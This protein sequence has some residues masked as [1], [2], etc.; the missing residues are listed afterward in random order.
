[1][2]PTVT[3][4]TPAWSKS[5][6]RPAAPA[7]V[8]VVDAVECIA[9]VQ[10][11]DAAAARALVDRLAP[12]V[13]R[14]VRSHLPRRME[15]SDLTQMVFAK[16]FSKLDQYSGRV[17]LEHW[18]S[19]VAVNTCLNALAYERVRPEIRCADLTE[20]QAAV[21][22][23]LSATESELPTEQ[24]FASRELVEK[25]LVQLG[26]K[27]R[28]VITLLH[29][30]GRS[31]EEVAQATGWS[32]AVVKVRAFRARNKMRGLLKQLLSEPTR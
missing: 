18:V 3:P 7:E 10:S 16:V 31:V 12:L 28:L 4:V 25:M 2:V 5:I 8:V 6:S 29:L 15:E 32:R 20:E 9:A 30:E 13:A 1:L 27:D 11:G 14:I 23:S 19:R 26:A 21:V 24:G 17:P 22:E